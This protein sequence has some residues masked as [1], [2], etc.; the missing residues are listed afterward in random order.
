MLFGTQKAKKPNIHVCRTHVTDTIEEKR[1]KMY[2]LKQNRTW[3]VVDS[4]ITAYLQSGNF[5]ST[6]RRA[7]QLLTLCGSK[8]RTSA[9]YNVLQ[10]YNVRTTEKYA[11]GASM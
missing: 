4:L 11:E 7:T 9:V 8:Y 5:A 10:E 2:S 6:Y 1:R 3:N